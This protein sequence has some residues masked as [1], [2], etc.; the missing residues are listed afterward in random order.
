MHLEGEKALKYVVLVTNFLFALGGIVLIG[1]G[2]HVQIHATRYLDFLSENYLNTPVFIIIAGS[3][4]FVIAFFGCCGAWYENTCMIYT[5]AFFLCAILIAE[6][7]AGIAALVLK[8]SLRDVIQDKMKDGMQN[9]GKRGFEGVT[10]AWDSMQQDLHCCGSANYTDWSKKIP[11]SC[12]KEPEEGCATRDSAQIF[13]QGC[14][15]TFEDEFVDNIGRVGAVIIGVGL[16]QVLVIL[17]GLLMSYLLAQR[18]KKESQHTPHQ[19]FYSPQKSY[20]ST[21][22]VTQSD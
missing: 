12:C 21:D 4:I 13:Q 9:Y 17:L 18:I 8:G 7:A 2:A 14:L 1:V 22:V 11:E 20:Q 15:T 16:V 3:I 5:Y 19:D 6:V 10:K